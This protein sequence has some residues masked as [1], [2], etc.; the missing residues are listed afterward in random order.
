MKYLLTFT[1][2]LI[3]GLA[4]YTVYNNS[5]FLNAL[6]VVFFGALIA[7]ALRTKAAAWGTLKLLQ[8]PPVIA[9]I[10]IGLGF[11]YVSM[12]GF[13]F[14]PSTYFSIGTAMIGFALGIIIYG[15]WNV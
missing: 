11:T 4:G 8:Q 9:L 1:A 14:W 15:I 7:H 2:A 5:S 13:N 3:T 12:D 10:V 6:A